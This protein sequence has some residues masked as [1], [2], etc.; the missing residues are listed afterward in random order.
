[1]HTRTFGPDGPAVAAIGQ[2]TWQM[3]A[4]PRNAAAALRH[5]VTL[6]LNHVDTAEIYGNG[7]VET[8]IGEALTGLRD[9]VFLVSKIDPARATSTEAER[10][11]RESLGRLR[12]D[13][14]DA[15]LLHWLPQ[16]SLEEAVE[17][18]ERLVER[19]LIRRWGV[20]N[21][22]EVKLE[23]AIRLAGPHRIACNQVLY[24]PG[25][26]AVEQAVVPCCQYHGIAMVGYSPFAV[27]AFP[28]PASAG[29]E[30]LEEVAARHGATPRQVTLAFL[31]RLPGT[32]T[33]PKASSTRHVEDNAAA[34]D[35]RLHPEDISR[36]EG[37][38]PLGRPR[39]G[40]P[41]W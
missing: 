10:A 18:M 34:A 7:A 12:T 29:A 22:D 20:S 23:E 25:E 4:N 32:F 24:H 5:G 36:L 38:F 11:C 40:V 3:D 31:T 13:H 2:G 1:M 41:M 9:E 39:P 17:S 21:F 14:L 16:H 6:G 15:Y 35:I 8:L 30:A 37:A 26:R 19:G 28:E 27:G 33:I